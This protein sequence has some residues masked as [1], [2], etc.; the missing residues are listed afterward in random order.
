MKKELIKCDFCER[1]VDE[2]KEAS[3]YE[4]EFQNCHG[5]VTHEASMRV[6]ETKKQICKTCANEKGLDW[7]LKK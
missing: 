1:E 5:W 2:K 6:Y 4:I 3:Y 7:Y